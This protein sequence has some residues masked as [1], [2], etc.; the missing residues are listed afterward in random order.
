MKKYYEYQLVS[1]SCVGV[2]IETEGS[3]SRSLAHSPLVSKYWSF[4]GDGSLIDGTEWIFKR[5]LKGADILYALD[6]LH[7]ASRARGLEDLSPISSERCSVH[8]H[9]DVRDMNKAQKTAFITLCYM[10]DELLFKVTGNDERREDVFCPPIGDLVVPAYRVLSNHSSAHKQYASTSTNQILVHG[11]IEFRHFAVPT[12]LK[13]ILYYIN[14]LL[15]IKKEAMKVD[16]DFDIDDYLIRTS[17]VGI[18]S[19]ILSVFNTREMEDKFNETGLMN[20]ERLVLSGI[21]NAQLAYEKECI[22]LKQLEGEE[23]ERQARQ[24]KRREKLKKLAEGEVVVFDDPII[25][26][27]EALKALN[28]IR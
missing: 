5:P 13:D 14:L 25:R 16:D 27:D 23:L 22:F 1:D 4:T 2:E 15:C 17:E 7:L 11:S 10:F 24:A 3:I 21:T 8:I 26:D 9:V 12:D 28:K 6:S 18:P 19:F 20:L